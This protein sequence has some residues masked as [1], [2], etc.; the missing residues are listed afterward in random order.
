MRLGL[1]ITP[2]AVHAVLC[3]SG[4][5]RWAGSAAYGSNA[6]LAEVV[7]RLAGEC[8]PRPRRARVV[9]SRDLV[10]VRSRSPAPPLRDRH[11]ARY[12][13]LEAPRLFRQ[14]GVPLAAGAVVHRLGAG[15]TVF[16]AVAA[17]QP[18]VEAVT[19]GCSQAGVALDGIGPA[20]DIIALALASPPVDGPL[21]VPCGPH[22]ETL[23]FEAGAMIGSRLR[24]AP[25][26][27]LPAPACTAALGSLPP[28]N[29]APAFAAAV[30]Q[31]SRFDLISP[32][33]AAARSRASRRRW[34][35]VAAIGVLMCVLAA[36]TYHVRLASATRG[37]ATELRALGPIVDSVM[38]VRRDIAAVHDVLSTITAAERDRSRHLALLAALT[39]A[40][41]DSS[42]I[43]ALT[44]AADGSVRLSG[45]APQA[46]RALADIERVPLL[47]AARL[48]GPVTRDR[49]VS[50]E[51][52]RFNILARLERRS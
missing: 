18:L 20:G 40:L 50:G 29:F 8:S 7:A 26:P 33:M 15:R 1:S 27:L 23:A 5:V 10:Q 47:R 22:G 19:D 30:A 46:A 36:G 34:N 32:A 39:Q 51:R 14:Q 21:D 31:S 9:L 48:E 41:E 43:T 52:D 49:R 16:V 6:D 45:F 25:D 37:V 2:A 35:A 13:G 42:V 17:S 24:R 12:V 11:L 38:A 4:T 44:I 3:D 28:E